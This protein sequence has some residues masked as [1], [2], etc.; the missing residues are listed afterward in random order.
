MKLEPV[1]HWRAQEWEAAL[2]PQLKVERKMT[3]VPF[4]PWSVIPLEVLEFE[5]VLDEDLLRRIRSIC[6]HYLRDQ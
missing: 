2:Q 5:A 6:S 3:V 1:W 4:P